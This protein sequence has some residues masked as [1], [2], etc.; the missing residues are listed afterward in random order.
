[1]PNFTYAAGHTVAAD[2]RKVFDGIDDAVLD[3]ARLT[4]SIIEAKKGSNLSA[5][6]G[7]RL[8]ESMSAG[9]AKVLEGRKDMVSAH[10]TLVAIKGESNLDV[11]D[12]GCLGDGPITGEQ[13]VAVTA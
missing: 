2:V 1:M 13:Q 5:V 8:L 3:V 11:V 4:I 12:Y 7:Q 10:R 6:K 9:M